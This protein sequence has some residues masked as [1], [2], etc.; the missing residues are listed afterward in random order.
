VRLLAGDRP[1]VEHVHGVSF[2]FETALNERRDFPIVLNYQNSHA[3]GLE[4]RLPFSGYALVT[5]RTTGR[6]DR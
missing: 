5:R 2:F 6:N 4:R 1:V 3:P